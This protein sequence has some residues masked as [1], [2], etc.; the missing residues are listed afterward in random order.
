MGPHVNAHRRVEGARIWDHGLIGGDGRSQ[1]KESGTEEEDTSHLIVAE[2][3]RLPNERKAYANKIMDDKFLALAT[4]DK[5]VCP[6]FLPPLSQRHFH[7]VLHC[8]LMAFCDFILGLCLIRLLH[9]KKCSCRGHAAARESVA[10]STFR[11][12]F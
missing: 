9:L 4:L 11:P 12:S 5:M 3:G 1:M 2:I 6:I 7:G 8:P 10:S